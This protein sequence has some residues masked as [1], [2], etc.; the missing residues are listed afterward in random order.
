MYDISDD[1]QIDQKE[2]TKLLTAMVRYSVDFFD[3]YYAFVF[4]M[5]LLVKQIVK[6]IMIRNIV[7]KKLLKNLMLVVIKN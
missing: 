7:H 2:L 6:E 1:G 5:I 3:T 4:S